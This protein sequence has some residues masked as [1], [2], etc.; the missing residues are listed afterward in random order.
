MN[1]KLNFLYIHEIQCFVYLKV[2]MYIF[3][4][5]LMELQSMCFTNTLI[6]YNTKGNWQ[7]VGALLSEHKYVCYVGA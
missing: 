2:A 3:L 7:I 5:S 1:S 4:T 6:I